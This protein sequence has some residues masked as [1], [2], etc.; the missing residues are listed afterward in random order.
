[1]TTASSLTLPASLEGQ[2]VACDVRLENAGGFAYA[3]MFSG[4]GPVEAA[5]TG[6]G[7]GTPTTPTTPTAPIDTARPTSR[8]R[9][10][11]C[12]K[13]GSKRR[14]C[15]ITIAAKDSDG[16]IDRI[17]AKLT[18]RRRVCRR[19]NGVRRCRRKKFTK[20]LRLRETSQDG[21]YLARVRLRRGRYTLTV[22][23]VD[24]AGHRSRRKVKRF[25][26]R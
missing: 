25:R 1:V 8:I 10:V 19:R 5:S 17:S 4:V 23:S 15:R 24:G 26:V 13:R 9:R 11:R 12:T 7:G 16:Q 6:G 14:R 3:E 22:V 21:V 2:L 20:R 18:F